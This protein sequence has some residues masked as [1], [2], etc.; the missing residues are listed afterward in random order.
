M[1]FNGA[2]ILLLG[3]IKWWHFVV[4][5][6]AVATVLGISGLGGY[7]SLSRDRLVEAIR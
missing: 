7:R 1:I 4:G 6:L 2:G 5:L 3:T